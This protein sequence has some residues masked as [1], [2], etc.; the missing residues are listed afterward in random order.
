M[1]D[2]NAIFQHSWYIGN[3]LQAILYGV[4]LVLYFASVKIMLGSK[5]RRDA[6]TAR[7]N[8]VLLWLSSGQL[9][10]ITISLIVQCF[11]GEAMWITNENYPGG[12]A[13]YFGAH[14]SVWYETLGSAACV[15]LSLMSDGFLIYRTYVVWNDWRVAV[16]PCMLYCG[17]AGLGIATCY[18]SGKPGAD[19]FLNLSADIALAYT[20]VVIALNF[21]CT[22]L[23]CSRILWVAKSMEKTLG[24]EISKTYTGAA[25]IVIESMLPYTLFGIAYVATLGTNH[26]TSILFLA[27]YVMATC[28]SPQLIILRVL[29]GRAWTKNVVTTTFRMRSTVPISHGIDGPTSYE[30]SPGTTINLRVLST[31]GSIPET[32]GDKKV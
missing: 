25:S 4:E 18:I 22:T 9:V 11:F 28:I 23:I 17:T 13:A 2:V 20:S 7:G 32:D 12:T 15:V 3:I 31:E 26:P 14:A 29:M 10:M 8:T 30:E 6:E 16:I 19:F 5:T 1:A 27:L 21:I 24:R